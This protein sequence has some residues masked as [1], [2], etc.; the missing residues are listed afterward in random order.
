MPNIEDQVRRAFAEGKFDNLPGKGKPLHL[1]D[2]SH[3][4]PEWRMAYRMLAGS[5][6]GLPWMHSRDEIFKSL[7]QARAELIRTW[8]WC[9]AQDSDEASTDA[10]V[11]AKEEWRRA[12][13]NFCTQISGINRQI[14]NYNLEAPSPQLHLRKIDALQ[15]INQLQTS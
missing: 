13:E 11:E 4:H 1:E 14:A 2:D 5:G 8:N 3:I 6:H 7:D 10:S 15:E 9:Q 12:Q